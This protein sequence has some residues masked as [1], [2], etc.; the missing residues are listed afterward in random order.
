MA[1]SLEL[2]SSL[3]GFGLYGLRVYEFRVNGF[4]V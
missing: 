1:E 2:V 4:R 3:S